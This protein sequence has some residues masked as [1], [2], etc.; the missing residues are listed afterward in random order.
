V[1]TP[2]EFDEWHQCVEVH[3]KFEPGRTPVAYCNY[4]GAW[5]IIYD[6]TDESTVIA[7]FEKCFEG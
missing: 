6:D 4:E 7:L 3:V 1:L 2:D 5:W